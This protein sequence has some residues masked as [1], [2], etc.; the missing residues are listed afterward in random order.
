MQTATTSSSI[1]TCAAIGARF[2][3]N[4]L[5]QLRTRGGEMG[6]SRFVGAAP[7]APLWGRDLITNQGPLL[8]DQ[9]DARQ[10]YGA[11]KF[12]KS[13]PGFLLLE[14]MVLDQKAIWTSPF[15]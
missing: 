13:R 14:N 12:L 10:G 7:A 11:R 4:P 9:A 1:G 2:G 8:R 15:H 6:G 3:G 5:A